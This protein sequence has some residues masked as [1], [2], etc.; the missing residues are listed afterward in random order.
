MCHYLMPLQYTPLLPIM[1]MSWLFEKRCEGQNAIRPR[2]LVY[3]P[4]R[5][6]QTQRFPQHHSD[7]ESPGTVCPSMT[8]ANALAGAFLIVFIVTAGFA[9]VRSSIPGETLGTYMNVLKFRTLAIISNLH[10]SFGQSWSY[11]TR[12]LTVE[13]EV[14]PSLSTP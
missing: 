2:L 4:H 9:I 5:N 11:R 3:R 14:N 10:W 12:N 1:N 8:T 7:F 6:A 13:K